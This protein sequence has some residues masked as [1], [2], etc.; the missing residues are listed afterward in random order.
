MKADADCLKLTTK[1]RGRVHSQSAYA[2]KFLDFVT[3]LYSNLLWNDNSH[4]AEQ[5]SET[6]LTT[7]NLFYSCSIQLYGE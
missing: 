4:S 5:S 2:Y 1:A 6:G 3:V 7:P